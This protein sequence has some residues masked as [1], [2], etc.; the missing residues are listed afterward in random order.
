MGSGEMNSRRDMLK[1]MGL[2]VAAVATVGSA[3]TL[4]RREAIAAFAQGDAAAPPWWLLAPL[5]AGDAIGGGW[6]LL[7]LS[8]VTRGAAVL[9]VRHHSGQSA[10]IHL[11]AWQDRP[12]GLAHSALL[13]LLLMDGGD[14]EHQT[15]EGLGRALMGL[16]KR[17]QRNE[18]EAAADIAPLA[19]MLTHTE[20]VALYGPETLV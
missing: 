13:D 19:R 16:A 14:G 2:G 5:A 10:S 1:T 4:E 6:R 7:S 12:R 3:R 11:C 15:D 17:I 20:R 18:I 8:A 9:T